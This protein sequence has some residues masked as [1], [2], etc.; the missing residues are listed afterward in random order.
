MRIPVYSGQFKKDLKTMQ[1]R[2]KDME[3]IKK[4]MC[5]LINEHPLPCTFYFYSLSMVV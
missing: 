3:K 1:K 5:F 4:L 2:G